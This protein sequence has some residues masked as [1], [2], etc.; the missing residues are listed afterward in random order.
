MGGGFWGAGYILSLDMGAGYTGVKNS[1]LNVHILLCMLYFNK[2]YREETI[3][4]QKRILTKI[5]VKAHTMYNTK[6]EPNVD[7]RH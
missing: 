1:L 2:I 3:W 7:Y 6:S 4:N 5:L